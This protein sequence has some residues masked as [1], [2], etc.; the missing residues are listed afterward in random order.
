MLFGAF[1]K[2]KIRRPNGIRYAT[3]ITGGCQSPNEWAQLSRTNGLSHKDSIAIYQSSIARYAGYK[4]G[5]LLSLW[6]GASP[7]GVAPGAVADGG[8]TMAFPGL[9]SSSGRCG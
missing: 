9:S 4:I 1:K 6:G 2:F 3:S 5:K 8:R 7:R